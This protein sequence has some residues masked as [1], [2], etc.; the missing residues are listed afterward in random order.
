MVRAFIA[1]LGTGNGA[2]GCPFHSW[3]E[4]D[5]VRMKLKKVCLVGRPALS[6]RSGCFNLAA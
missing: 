6:R 3:S 2:G 5:A 1:T 4:T